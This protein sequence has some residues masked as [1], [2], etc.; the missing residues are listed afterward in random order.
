MWKS[1]ML[2]VPRNDSFSR[3]GEGARVL[4]APLIKLPELSVR[5]KLCGKRVQGDGGSKGAMD[6]RPAISETRCREDLLRGRGD[7]GEREVGG[8]PDPIALEML[9]GFGDE[10]GDP[11]AE[12]IGESVEGIA[13][14]VRV[15]ND[16]GL[17]MIGG[18]TVLMNAWLCLG[19]RIGSAFFD[20]NP[21]SA[22]GE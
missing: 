9:E 2:L 1:E 19:V 11:G 18:V 12:T 14:G 6:T 8:R 21:N 7:D 13:G 3:E 20:P 17:R 10:G 4:E 16:I 15:E 5:R 22:H